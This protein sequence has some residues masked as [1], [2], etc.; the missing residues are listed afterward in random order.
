MSS[1][2]K[3]VASQNITFVMVNASTG[4]ADTGATVTVYVTKDNGAQATGVGTVTNSGH[5]QYNYAPT[6]AETNATDVGFLFTATGDIPVNYDFHTDV[7]DANG[8]VSVNVADINGVT[9][10]NPG[11]SG[12][13]LISGS[14]SGTTTFGAMTC[15]G[16]FT[17]SDGLLVSRST[18]NASAFT[19]SGNGTGSGVVFTGGA[20]GNGAQITGGA[21]SGDAF[22]IT[23]PVLGNGVNITAN[24]AAKVGLLSTGG[25]GSGHGANFV[26]KGTGAGMK[27][28]GNTSGQGFWCQGGATGPGALFAGGGTSGDSIDQTSVSGNAYINANVTNILG[29][30]SAGAAG[31]VA[32]DGTTALTES[33]AAQGAG[34]TLAQGIYGITQQLG[35][36]SI[37]GTTMTVLKRDNATTAKTYTLNSSTAPTSITEAT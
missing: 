33:Y 8:F 22:V 26:G 10:V 21:T 2:Q 23:S 14:N 19:A 18:S 36:Q 20:T 6:Q 34:L 25:T 16:S 1:L 28:T 30:A 24:G 29:T 5:G 13:L 31:S 17:I 4:A 11:A 32:I 3:N 35:S 27:L 9:Q 7:V 37:A 12:G 15:T